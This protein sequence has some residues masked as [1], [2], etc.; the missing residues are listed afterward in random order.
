MTILA[1]LATLFATPIAGPGDDIKAPG[2]IT[3][4]QFFM[5]LQSYGPFFVLTLVMTVEMAVRCHKLVM[6]A[7]R[8]EG[9]AKTK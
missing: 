9:V 6:K 2:A 4:K 7:T 1:C 3:S 8:M 5:L